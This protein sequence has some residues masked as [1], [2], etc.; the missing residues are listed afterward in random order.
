MTAPLRAGAEI[1]ASPAQ[2]HYLGSVMRRGAG[3]PVRLFNGVDGEWQARIAFL[4][5]DRATLAPGQL[6]RPQAPESDL[7]L[8]FAPLKRDATDLVAQKATELGAAALLPVFTERTN[9]GRVNTDRLAAIAIEAAEQ[10][11]RLTVPR[12]EAPRQLGELLADWPDGRR[13]VVA[14]EREAGDPVPPLTGPTALLVGP[15]GGFTPAE[16]DVLRRHP[17]VHPATLGP[18]ILRAETAAIVGLAL[19][20]ARS[21]G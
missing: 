10:C 11:E 18:R 2:A 4:K 17:L 15:E 12:I 3:D 14:V 16:L 8:V 1:A 7:W 20:Q 13:L 5:R 6:L 9:A 19:L 21:G